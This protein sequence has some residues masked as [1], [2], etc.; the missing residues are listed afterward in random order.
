M[1]MSRYN[2]RVF[3]EP[4]G[5]IR[6]IQLVLGLACTGASTNLT[7]S[8]RPQIF[9][10]LA[11]STTTSFDTETSF[12]ISCYQAETNSHVQFQKRTTYLVEYPFNQGD[13]K[14][15]YLS[16]CSDKETETKKLDI[17]FSS[18]AQFFVAT[19]VLC[20]LYCLGALF[21]YVALWQLYETNPVY[22]IGDLVLTAIFTV[23]WFAGAAAWAVNVSDIKYYTGPRYLISELGHCNKTIQG[24]SYDCFPE[25][26]GK[27]S[28]LYISLVGCS[29]EFDTSLTPFFTLAQIFG[30][31]NLFLW[32]SSIWFVYKET[33]F[34]RK[35][36][37]PQPTMGQGTYP[38]IGPTGVPVGQMGQ[39]DPSAGVGAAQY[40]QYAQ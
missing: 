37:Q 2:T 9:A 1:D 38:G 4:R 3:K 24:F 29:P 40:Q 31:A 11:F 15:N 14:L 21:V 22:T 7:A 27:W 5:M 10:I 20:L 33:Q 36:L 35:S 39:M 32:G 8:V 17:N 6:V 28:T 13:T 26:P 19:G 23:F 34:H 12:T 16:R 25:S 30:F 18:S